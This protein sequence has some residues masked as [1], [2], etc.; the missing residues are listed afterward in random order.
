MARSTMASP[1]IR[2]G[3][4]SMRAALLVMSALAALL[5]GCSDAGTQTCKIGLVADLPLVPGTRLPAVEAT[6]DG[7][8][9]LVYIDTGA[10]LSVI[11]RPAA[12]RFDLRAGPEGGLVRIS[13]IGGTVNAPV[14]KVPRLGLG[15]GVAHELELPVAG[16]LGGPVQ[17]VP[18]LGLFGGDFLSNYDVD[19]DVPGHRFRMYR[20]QS[21][22]SSMHPLEGPAFSVPFTL[23]NAKVVL[24]LKLNGK[25][26]TGFLDSGATHSLV[27]ISLARQA[28]VAAADMKA[29]RIAGTRG[30]DENTID[31]R[32]HRF[33]SLEIGDE[34]MK[35]FR[36]GV[37]DT[38]VDD[39]IL[40]DDFLRFNHVWISYPLKRLFIQPVVP[41][42]LGHSGP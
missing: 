33:G 25:P 1:W 19:L 17:G 28:G 23:D 21:C 13:G 20:L 14:V 3:S 18:V 5:A 38:D 41:E 11:S 34:T 2:G 16:D 24:D 10:D 29:D 37:V 39:M 27:P 40:G 22:G 35:N 36:F 6:L 12:D 31:A 26:V 8:K 42:Q 30:I 32:V 9:A 4:R 15:T 7:Q